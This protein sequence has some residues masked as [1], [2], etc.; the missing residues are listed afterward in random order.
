VRVAPLEAHRIWAATYDS[1]LNPVLALEFR[2][3]RNA[4]PDLR[5]K[6]FLDAGCGTGRWLAEARSRGGEILGADA[7]REMLQKAQAK[8]GLAGRLLEADLSR[9]PLP[10]ACADF[11]LCA[12]CLSYVASLRDA[13][14]ELARVA[15]SQALVIITD[16]HPMAHAHGW[17][18][19][20]RSGDEVYEIDQRPSTM[21][22]LLAAARAAGLELQQVTEP[23][24]G[25]PERAIFL[26]AGKEQ[27]FEEA[28]NVPA[29]LISR[30]SRRAQ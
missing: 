26:R 13:V 28:R 22:D 5:G 11:V 17:T 6:R 10:E 19:S 4:L 7:C 20:F 12:F 29:V 25:D 23:C 16:L 3:L 24:F 15:K 14:R 18:R 21:D 2:T 1:D 9:L 30:W 8:P 27:L